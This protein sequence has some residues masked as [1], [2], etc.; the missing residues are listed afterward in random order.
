MP[1]SI[2]IFSQIYLFKIFELKTWKEM[3]LLQI[4]FSHIRIKFITNAIHCHVCST[5]IILLNWED[6]HINGLQNGSRTIA[7]NTIFYIKL[8][9]FEASVRVVTSS[10]MI[11]SI[12]KALVCIVFASIFVFMI[13]LASKC[14]CWLLFKRHEYGLSLN[15]HSQENWTIFSGLGR[16]ERQEGYNMPLT[17]CCQQ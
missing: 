12:C 14:V 10:A 6:T 3:N 8:R 11:I 4:L 7:L 17:S 15:L 13:R 16:K 1:F 2:V 9:F 5:K